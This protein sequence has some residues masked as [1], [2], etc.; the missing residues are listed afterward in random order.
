MLDP[1]IVSTGIRKG[2]QNELGAKR[3]RPQ[4]DAVGLTTRSDDFVVEW[5]IIVWAH[6][7]DGS[8]H[9]VSLPGKAGASDSA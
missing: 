8:S 7:E 1:A 6:Q 4:G 5:Q 2:D 9:V 3:R